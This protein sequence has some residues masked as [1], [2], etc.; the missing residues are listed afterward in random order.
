MIKFGI[1][2]NQAQMR[3]YWLDSTSNQEHRRYLRSTYEKQETIDFYDKAWYN[4][5]IIK[6]EIDDFNS[7]SK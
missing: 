7:E 5:N 1:R 3:F 6:S 2:G 4:I